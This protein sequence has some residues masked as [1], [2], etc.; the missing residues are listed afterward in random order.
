MEQS[1]FLGIS[2]RGAQL[3]GL[4][5]V[6]AQMSLLGW[7]PFPTIGN[8]PDVDIVAYKIF[9]PSHIGGMFK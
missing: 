8:F 4:Y 2:L 5:S 7:H 9:V 3:T 1:E 6:A